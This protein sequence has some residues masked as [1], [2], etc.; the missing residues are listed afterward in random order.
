MATA[1][2]VRTDRGC[3]RQPRARRRRATA[4]AADAATIA[5]AAA[6]SARARARHNTARD[7]N[8]FLHS[9]AAPVE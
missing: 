6:R 5:G 9:I 7:V 2:P 4:A 8:F 3:R 1:D